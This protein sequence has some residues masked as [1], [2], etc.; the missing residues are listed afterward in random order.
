MHSITLLSKYATSVLMNSRLVF[1]ATA[2]FAVT[3]GFGMFTPAMAAKMPKADVCHFEDA[4]VDEEGNVVQEAYWT[5]INING[6]AVK[7]HEGK[8][9]D[10]TTTDF[11]INTPED[12]ERCRSLP[13][14]Q[15]RVDEDK[16][17]E[18]GTE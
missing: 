16:R 5:I 9:G 13:N 6:N 7:A 11:V 8:H 15:D 2:L 1:A 12:E 17:V 18:D 3:I 4:V 10:G 14:F